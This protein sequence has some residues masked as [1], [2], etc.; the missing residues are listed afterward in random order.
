MA[1]QFLK[2]SPK[3]D[4]KTAL[5]ECLA[6]DTKH[7]RKGIASTLVNTLFTLTEY[8]NYVLEVIGTN[9]KAI[10]FYNKL[11]FKIA[12]IKPYF[13]SVYFCLK[14]TKKEKN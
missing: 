7:L 6:I 5:I 2:V 12:Y 4:E 8:E 13:P 11:G 3:L 9:K 10:K 14:Y 1:K